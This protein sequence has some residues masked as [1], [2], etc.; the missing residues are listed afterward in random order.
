MNNLYKKLLLGAVTLSTASIFA[1][2]VNGSPK[3]VS[4][5]SAD[6]LVS[7]DFYFALEN[8]VM[9]YEYEGVMYE[10]KTNSDPYGPFG[11]SDMTKAPY[12]YDGK[13]VYKGTIYTTEQGIYYLRFYKKAKDGGR[14]SVGI[15]TDNAWIAPEVFDNKIYVYGDETWVSINDATPVT[16][17]GTL[18]FDVSNDTNFNAQDTAWKAAVYFFNDTT[19]ENSWSDFIVPVGAN[20][21]YFE[22]SYALTYTPEKFILVRYNPDFTENYWRQDP[23]GDNPGS[24]KW[25]KSPKWNQSANST[26]NINKTHAIAKNNT[27]YMENN[28]MPRFAYFPDNTSS[29]PTSL[30]VMPGHKLNGYKNCEYFY[31]VDLPANSGFRINDDLFSKQAYDNFSLGDGVDEGDITLGNK[32]LNV[33]TARKYTIF[34]DIKNQSIHIANPVRAEADAWAQDF[35]K[36]TCTSNKE[37]W[38]LYGSRFSKLSD[39]AKALFVAVEHESDPKKDLSEQG[40]YVMAVQRYDYVLV[41]YGTSKYGDFM[42]R[43]EAHKVTPKSMTEV[44]S[45]DNNSSNINYSLMIIIPIVALLSISTLVIIRKKEN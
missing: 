41:L 5:V 13:Q 33:N 17:M 9:K 42:G 19:K 18:S 16:A 31:T 45:Y 35:L 1:L 3:E 40:Y 24:Y 28:Y 34:Y 27:L 15:V 25:E 8:G 12:I 7:H 21:G 22:V 32:K 37:S 36:V 39:E 43:V 30:T 14:Q 20:E 38:S 2:G 10:H 29:S 44:L 6:A 4:E 26:F 23:W 11:M